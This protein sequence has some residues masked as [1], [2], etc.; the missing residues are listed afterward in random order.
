MA[1]AMM[2]SGRTNLSLLKA[3]RERLEPLF[4]KYDTLDYLA[5]GKPLIGEPEPYSSTIEACF[6]GD[7]WPINFSDLDEIGKIHKK[8][9]KRLA[10][11]QDF[12]RLMQGVEHLRYSPP[13]F[14]LVIHRDPNHPA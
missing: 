1:S 3:L 8:D 14:E 13:S 5:L 11:Y 7:V 12:Q 6:N 10:L 2:V 9:Y 4:V